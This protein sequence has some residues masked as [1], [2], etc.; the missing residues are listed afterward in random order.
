MVRTYLSTA[1]DSPLCRLSN[2]IVRL[3]T[4]L[5]YPDGQACHD[6]G[7]DYVTR[8]VHG[9]LVRRGFLLSCRLKED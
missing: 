2:A 4:C 1:G 8:L 5:K 7:D 9:T 3:L 6:R